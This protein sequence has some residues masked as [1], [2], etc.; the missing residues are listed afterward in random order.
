MELRDLKSFIEV[1]NHKSFTNAADHSYLTQSSL[2]KA[3]KKL[4]NEL[5]V[6]LFDRSTRHLFLTDAGEVVYQQSQKAFAVL[7]EMNLLLDDLRNVTTGEIKIGI[8]PLIGTLFFPKIANDFYKYYPNV[9]LKLVEQ[10]AKLIGRLVE[11]AQI[12]VGIVVLP[13]NEEKLNISPF[14]QDDFVLFLHKDHKLAQRTSVTLNELKNEKFILFTKDFTLHDY[15]IQTCERSGFTPSISYQSSQWDLIIELVSSKL[16]ITLLPKSIYKKQNNK[17][18]K[19]VEIDN[20]ALC[21]KIGIITK[22]DAYQSFALKEF[23]KM[24]NKG[25]EL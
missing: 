25:F 9:S 4:E 1:A 20:S 13:A 18:I 16:G 2:S 11:D 15:I 17:N 24:L 23:L 19:I 12:D 10:G 8:P 22:K 7:T 5:G 6:E 14:I 3:I 21:W